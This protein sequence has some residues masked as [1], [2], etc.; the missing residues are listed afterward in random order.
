MSGEEGEWFVM[1]PTPPKRNVRIDKEM[2]DRDG[3]STWVVYKMAFTEV[4]AVNFLREHP[5]GYRRH[6]AVKE[7]G[8]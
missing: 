2:V 7:T 6:V 1:K 4:Q 5:T 8:R 3:N